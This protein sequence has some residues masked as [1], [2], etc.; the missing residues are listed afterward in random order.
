MEKQQRVGIHQVPPV[1]PG[2]TTPGLP[3]LLLRAG[4]RALPTCLPPLWAGWGTPS[5]A[6]APC[7]LQ[8]VWPSGQAAPGT[9]TR[10]VLITAQATN[11]AGGRGPG[12]TR[13]DSTLL[14]PWV[15]G[16]CT[17]PQSHPAPQGLWRLEPM[18]PHDPGDPGE[19]DAWQ[20]GIGRV[21]SPEQLRQAPHG[22]VRQRTPQRPGRAVRPEAPV[23]LPKKKKKK[24]RNLSV[25]HG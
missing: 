13:G 17:V 15:W 8:R 21:R 11:T 14:S 6:K 1:P 16:L 24:G 2:V 20:T 25:G 19:G 12:V 22:A 7:L 10:S 23:R 5:P 4:R 18:L 9:G 3:L